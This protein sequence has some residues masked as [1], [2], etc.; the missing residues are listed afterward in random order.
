MTAEYKRVMEARRAAGK[1]AMAEAAPEKPADAESADAGTQAPPRPEESPD[2]QLL[3]A[4]H[5]LGNRAAQFHSN[6]F[7]SKASATANKA[8]RAAAATAV[9]AVK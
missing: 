3:P 6:D 9:K 1:E 7:E 2:D 8:A 4:D 5:M